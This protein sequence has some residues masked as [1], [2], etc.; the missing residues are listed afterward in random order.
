MNSFNVMGCLSYQIHYAFHA[1]F[2]VTVILYGD[3]RAKI[4]VGA[5]MNKNTCNKLY[6]TLIYLII[7]ISM[8][9]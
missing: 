4:P 8:R 2:Y 9:V 7:P 1:W 3:F 5:I 6:N